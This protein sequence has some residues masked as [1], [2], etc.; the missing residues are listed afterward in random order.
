MNEEYKDKI[1]TYFIQLLNVYDFQLVIGINE[2]LENTFRLKDIQEGNLNG[3]EQEE[4]YT[5]AD[6]IERLDSYHQDYVYN[7]LEMKQEDNIK[8]KKD[9]WDLVTKRYL[10]SNTVAKVLSEIHPKEYIDLTTKKE[11]REIC[12]IK[13]II[14]ILDDEE[15]FYK[16]VCEKYICTMSKEMLLYDNKILHIFIKDEYIDLKEKGKINSQ[17]YKEYLDENFET[18][19]YNFYQD[20]YD[21]VIKDNIAY[22]LNDL[23]LFSTDGEWNFY[24]TFEELKKIGY[25]FMVKDQYPLIEKYVIPC[26][27]NE[28]IFDF[29]DYFTL[30]ELEDFENSLDLYFTQ[31]VIYNQ[32]YDSLVSRECSDFN[33]DIIRLACGLITYDDFISDYIDSPLTT[34]DICLSRVASYFRENNIKDLMDYGSDA[35][36]GL[37]HLSSLYSKIMDKLD[38]KY[39]N[40]FTEDGIANGKYLTTITYEDNSQIQLDTSAWNGI[41]VVVANI[42]SIYEKYEKIQNKIKESDSKNEQ[43]IDYNYN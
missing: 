34:Y 12:E 18:R 38:I 32:E 43:E 10:E 22:D 27:P 17:N 21:F 2:N 16:S 31:D 9:D 4:F 26:I 20:L 37:Y 25:G 3:I 5:L 6:I 7:I 15:K 33:R 11:K 8:L 28:K 1:V 41:K 14:N 42:E 23:E 19:E 30:E 39:T 24:I 13:D 35:D 40:I 29:Y 36:E